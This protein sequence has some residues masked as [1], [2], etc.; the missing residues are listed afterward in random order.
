MVDVCA[1]QPTCFASF[2]LEE[3]MF[4]LF[5]LL[6][7]SLEHFIVNGC[8]GDPILFSSLVMFSARAAWLFSVE[9]AILSNAAEV[10][11]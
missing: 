4:L 3:F 11:F 7:L 8:Y 1:V 10:E 9:N 5:L 6:L 2:D